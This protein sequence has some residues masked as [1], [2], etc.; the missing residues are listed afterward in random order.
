MINVYPKAVGKGGGGTQMHL[1]PP[2]KKNIFL[3]EKNVFS[4][5]NPKSQ[6]FFFHFF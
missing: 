6:I 3:L 4:P 5:K 1:H 2:F